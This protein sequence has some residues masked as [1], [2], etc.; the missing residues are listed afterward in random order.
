M[1]RLASSAATTEVELASS[2]V[3][4]PGETVELHLHERSMVYMAV[5]AYG[6]PLLSLIGGALL[7]QQLGGDA[8]G[9]LGCAIGLA[10]GWL[11]ARF[12]HRAPR[13]RLQT[14]R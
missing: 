12:W 10:M 11:A 4:T 9:L 7:G 2:T 14:P 1:A 6:V 5:M 13:I 3:F 8:G